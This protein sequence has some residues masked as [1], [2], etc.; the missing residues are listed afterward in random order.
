MDNE[1]NEKMHQR[2]A[3]IA[4][5]VDDYDDAIEFYTRKLDFQLLEDTLNSCMSLCSKSDKMNEMSTFI[6][7]LQSMN[8]SANKKRQ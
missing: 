4:L 8:L 7:M 3:H 5:V 1:K 2:I 6:K